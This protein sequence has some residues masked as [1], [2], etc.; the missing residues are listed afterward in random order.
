MSSRCHARDALLSLVCGSES[1][2]ASPLL[3]LS[4]VEHLL[5]HKTGSLIVD[6][7]CALTVSSRPAS[8]VAY[9]RLGSCPRFQASFPAS[10]TAARGSV[11]RVLRLR[12]DE[13][14]G[15]PPLMI[16]RTADS[17]HAASAGI[18][19]LSPSLLDSRVK[20]DAE[21][22]GGTSACEGKNEISSREARRGLLGE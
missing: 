7:K 4:F 3:L 15:F 6:F 21:Q 17:R 11:T 10:H 12:N 5:S 18:M 16:S 2:V 14:Q 9:R 19:S 22:R 1:D 8:R 13:S 20:A